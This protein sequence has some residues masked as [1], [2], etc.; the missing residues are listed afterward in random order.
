MLKR[1]KRNECV[2]GGM[3][4]KLNIEEISEYNFGKVTILFAGK[5]AH[6]FRGVPLASCPIPL[7]YHLC[8][9]THSINMR[10]VKG[11][12]LFNNHR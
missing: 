6:A 7:F 8:F 4:I 10:L 9:A 5:C 1:R 2:H 11:R 12:C 3:Y